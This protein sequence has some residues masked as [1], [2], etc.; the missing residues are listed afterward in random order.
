[1][2]REWA[3]TTGSHVSWTVGQWLNGVKVIILQDLLLLEDSQLQVT[4]SF[5]SGNINTHYCSLVPYKHDLF[6]HY[7]T[8]MSNARCQILHV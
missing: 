8:N 1:M 6:H 5:T 4:S 3:V 2:V 7:T